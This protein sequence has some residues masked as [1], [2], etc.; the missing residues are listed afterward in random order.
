MGTTR[1]SNKDI[2][3][4][5]EA[6]TAAI[7]ALASAISG[8]MTAAKPATPATPVVET[9]TPVAQDSAKPKVDEAYFNHMVAKVSEKCAEDG[10]SRVLY[11]RRNGHGE[12]KLAYC[13]LSRFGS[14]RDRGFMGALKQIDPS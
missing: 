2:L 3:N 6:Q 4:A 14:L 11:A 8:T 7:G 13:L 1:T 9:A 5:I 12:T 10:E